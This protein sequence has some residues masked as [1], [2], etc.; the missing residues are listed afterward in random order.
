LVESAGNALA[1][2]RYVR[3]KAAES[4]DPALFKLAAALA[5]EARQCELAAWELASRESAARPRAPA[6]VPWLVKPEPK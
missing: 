6:S 1:D 5:T 3:A 2:S 4:G